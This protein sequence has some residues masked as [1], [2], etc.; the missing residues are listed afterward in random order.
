MLDIKKPWAKLIL[1]VSAF[2]SPIV[3]ALTGGFVFLNCEDEELR[4]ENKKV[5]FVVLIFVGLSML[6]SIWSSILA[7]TNYNSDAYKVYNV[8]GA[9][10]NIAKII[11]YVVFA[12]LALFTKSGELECCCCGEHACDSQSEATAKIEETENAE[13]KK[14]DNNQ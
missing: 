2:V 9:L 13:V 5:F 1:W 11:T 12:I 4:N 14:E 8:F 10:I 7:M 6:M 3:Y